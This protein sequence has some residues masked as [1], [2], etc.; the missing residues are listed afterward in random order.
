MSTPRRPGIYVEEVPSA[1][2]PIEGVGT[3]IAAFVG[4]AAGGPVNRPIRI[5]SLTQFGKVYSD[6]RRPENGP[7][8]PNAYLAHAVHGFFENGGR[9]CWVI[10]AGQRGNAPGRAASQSA[11][12]EPSDSER[13]VALREAMSRLAAIDEVTMI[14][15]PDV[16][17]L[18]QGSKDDAP[19]DLASALVAQC[20]RGGAPM[21]ILDP[22]P[23]LRPQGVVDWRMNVTG[24]ESGSAALYY[25]WIEVMDPL[26]DR[27]TLVPPSGHVAG[28]WART[29]S[30]WGIHRPPTDA[31]LL[32]ARGLAFRIRK[33]EQGVLD[34]AGVNSIRSFP[35]RGIRVWGTRTLSSDPEWRYLNARRLVS[36]VSES[37]TKGTRWAVFE[38]ND[39]ELWT[40]LRGAI[41][42]FL[43]RTWLDGALFG[44]SPEQA[45]YVKCDAE[46][47]P[48][49]AIEAG[50][51]VVEIGIAP[52]K[53]EEPAA[54]VPTEFVV[55][56][57]SQ[58]TA[59]ASEV[60]A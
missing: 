22:P 11:A 10:R 26:S 15:M 8:V 56:R 54:D 6:R 37:I 39:E 12:I 1:S 43:T 13:T 14:A 55:F 9:V 58:F 38:P 5:S 4:F 21:A 36:Y 17:T 51:V 35:G 29:D 60:T 57:I 49:D 59:G 3:A 41:S 27:P 18:A 47:N 19:A 2:K 16:M 7:F 46:T 30:T 48:P 33:A 31:A 32:G 50:Q 24:H 44:S 45:F 42:N 52:T 40:Q 20:D 53:P 25:P 23:A 28:V 34:E